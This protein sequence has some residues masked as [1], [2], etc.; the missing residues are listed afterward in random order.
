MS[1]S[2]ISS[3]SSTTSGVTSTS[4]FGNNASAPVTFQGLA[5]NLPTQQLIAAII[6]QESQPMVRMQAQQATNNNKIAAL[7]TLSADLTGLNNSLDNLVLSGFQGNT[8]TSSD[9]TNQYVSATASGATS[10][11]YDVTVKALATRARVVLPNAMQPNS[12]VGQGAY[13]LTDMAGN[14]FTINIDSTNNTLAGLASA[15][16]KATDANGD[17]ADVN[18]SLIQTGADG[19]S[20][21]VLSANNTGVGPS[22]A[23]TFS[24]QAPAGSTL[25]AQ[26]SFSS[27]GTA[28]TLPQSVAS[29]TAT[30]GA[31]TYNLTDTTGATASVTASAT[32]TLATLA[33]KIN[34]AKTSGG[35]ILDV[36]ASVQT[37]GDGTQQLVLTPN[38]GATGGFSFQAAGGSALQVPASGAATLTSTAATNAD[39]FL[40]GVEMQ[41]A[42]NSVSDAVSGVTFNLNS[43][44]T[45]LNQSTTITVGMDTGAAT[46]AMQAVVTAYNQFYKDY[47]SNTKF[48]QNTDGSYTAGVFNMDMSVRTIVNQVSNMLM[49]PPSGLSTSSQYNSPAS[50]GLSTNEDGTISLDSSAFATALKADPTAVQN[51]FGSSGSSTSPLLSFVGATAQTTTSPI[52][53]NVSQ[54]G[55]GT[56]TG[57]FQ[58]L[59]PDGTTQTNTLT[60][61]DGYFY[62]GAGT[63]LQGLV[64]QGYAGASGTLTVSPGVSALTQYLDTNLS[65]STPGDLGGLVNDLNANNAT[66]LTQIQSQQSYLANSQAS[67][68][69][70]YANL[71]STVS[72]LQSAGSSLAT[73][74]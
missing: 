10:G 48:T 53:F 58:N 62:G 50:I 34:A 47:T 25:N 14:T 7:T 66:L 2:S 37:N 15:I 64:L 60:S 54:N 71:E 63:A 68:Q 35:A 27:T 69:T 36:T 74:A 1:S 17:A 65:S 38:A 43:A 39:F 41:R 19:S 29:S 49:A 67:L 28:L 57:T 22:G 13:T 23:T 51:I 4:L 6:N 55:D 9:S 59:M 73:L 16:N 26:T 31:G 72:S 46:T 5:T 56:L 44:Q 8:V 20:Q 18:A 11:T 3:T 21:L 70:E 40:N 30:V 42:S 32:D 45:N 52:T 33:Q 24:L 61:T 12:P